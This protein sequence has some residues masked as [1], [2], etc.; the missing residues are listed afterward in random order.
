MTKTIYEEWRELKNKINNLHG[1]LAI[2]EGRITIG[3]SNTRGLYIKDET[4]GGIITN[5]TEEEA[6]FITN[7][8][9]KIFGW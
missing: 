6:R 5:I 4:A 1:K 2:T 9:A 3:P 7:H 8:F